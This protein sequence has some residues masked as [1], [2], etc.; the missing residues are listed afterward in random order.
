[1]IG[2]RG[3]P[4]VGFGEAGHRWADVVHP[5]FWSRISADSEVATI[6]NIDPR[7]GKVMREFVGKTAFVTG[8]A[9]GIGLA[10]GRAFAE[11]GCKVMLAD[12]E[13]AALDAAVA[14]LSDSGPEIRGVVCDVADTAS[15]DAAAEA[16]FSAFGKVHILCNNAG[17]GARG[18]IDHIALDNWH[19]VLDVNLIG[20]VNCVRAFLPRMRAH[21]EG[22]HI[23]NTASM[24]GMVNSH[25]GFAPYPASKFAV[26][27]M[28]EGLA[29]ELKPFGIG[30]SILCPGVVRTNILESARNR[31]ERYGPP[32]PVDTAN[33]VYASF[34]ERVRTGMDPAEVAQR[35]LAA[36][37]DDELYVFTHPVMR[38]VVEERFRA[39]LAAFDRAAAAPV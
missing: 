12:I 3:G 9:S 29:V 20:V 28:S 13:K 5:D 30:V 21:G 24:A 25:Q 1:M 15:A 10:L 2:W 14:S 19:W 26:V 36:I 11:A 39:I 37:R 32:T 27:G 34:A 6:Q 4:P 17:V 22:G 38:G 23:V 18:G 16:S 7:E 35:V 8:G 33:P 31:P